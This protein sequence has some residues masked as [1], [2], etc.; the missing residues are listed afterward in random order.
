MRN[1]LANFS[2]VRP[3]WCIFFLLLAVVGLVAIKQ[4]AARG[5]ATVRTGPT[6]NTP[7][8]RSADS[9][10]PRFRGSNGSAISDQKGIPVEWSERDYLWQVTLP[11]IGHSSPCVWGDR[12]FVTSA[13]DE[14]RRRLVLCLNAATGDVNWTRTFAY[15]TFKKHD[16]NS[17]ASSTPAT[18][19]QRVYVAFDDKERYTLMAFEFDGQPAWDLDLGPYVSQHGAGVS[20]VVHDGIV[21][22]ANDQDGPSFVIAVDAKTGEPR[23]K[24]DRAYKE[25]ATS[26]AAP[27]ILERPGV[28]TEVVFASLMEG[29]VAYDARTG[30]RHWGSGPFKE[31]TVSSPAYGLGMI[32][33]TSGAGGQGH[34]LAAVRPRGLGDVEV[35]WT[36]TRELPYVPTPLVYGED[37][38]LW[39]DKGVLMCLDAASGDE[40]GSTRLQGN[41]S[42]SPICIDGKLYCIDDGGDVF[43]V[44]ASPDLEQLAQNSLGDPSRATPAVAGGRLFLRTY[45]KLFCIGRADAAAQSE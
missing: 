26:Y 34:F 39:G 15:E 35:V 31:R 38:Y 5:E 16:R 33:Q 40:R 20:P 11:G 9:I 27:F 12:V 43:V 30:E 8:E 41:F 44:S 28:P 1:R 2:V 6:S 22:L 7:S 42:G 37:L 17:Y 21:Y 32:F 13:E 18:D 24:V 10:W 19:G 3:R 14:G 36:R 29:L 25:G 23:W 45:H 4:H